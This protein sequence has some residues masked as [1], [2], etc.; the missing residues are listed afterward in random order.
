MDSREWTE[1]LPLLLALADGAIRGLAELLKHVN[2][3]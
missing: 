2:T 3:R 1:L